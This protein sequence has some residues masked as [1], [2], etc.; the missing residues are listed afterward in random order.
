LDESKLSP[1]DLISGSSGTPNIVLPA[2]KP[3]LVDPI[4]VNDFPASDFQYYLASQDQVMYA[5]DLHDAVAQL[6]SLEHR[7][8]TSNSNKKSETC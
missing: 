1:Q 5:A 4:N 7:F 2:S 3:L 8:P 6:S